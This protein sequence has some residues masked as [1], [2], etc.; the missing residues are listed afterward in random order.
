[1]A[2]N[3]RLLARLYSVRETV[4]WLVTQDPVYVPLFERIEADIAVEE[5]RGDI[6]AHARAI[7]RLSKLLNADG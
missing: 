7:V 4:A 6:V 2:N 3:Q 5:A 1:M